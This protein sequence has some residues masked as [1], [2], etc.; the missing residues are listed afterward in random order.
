MRHID[1]LEARFGS[2]RVLGGLCLV[3]T[4]LN[5]DG[6]VFH[7]G[8]PHSIV[9]G[10]RDGVRTQ[11][12]DDVSEVL[13]DAGFDLRVS[14]DILQDMWE[15]WVFLATAAGI[16]SL[17]RSSIGDILAAGAGDVIDALHAECTAIA[18]AA[19]HEPRTAARERARATFTLAESNLTASMFR[20]IQA[21]ARVE[22]DHVIGDLLRRA[23]S[24]LEAPVLR[25]A[26]AHLKTY[27]ARRQREMSAKQE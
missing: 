9:F 19:G 3:S 7:F 4:V 14:D 21:G 22:A 11:A 12:V 10:S 6:S 8:G 26:F 18:R 13:S 24:Y 1:L 27:E 5:P 2:A 17:M 15:K 25:T 20:D 23:G 16:T